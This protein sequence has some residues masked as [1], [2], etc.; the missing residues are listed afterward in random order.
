MRCCGAPG[1]CE[2]TVKAVAAG[3][4][5]VSVKER[6]QDGCGVFPPTANHLLHNRLDQRPSLLLELQLVADLASAAV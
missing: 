5:I 3:K 2:W 1:A 4:V 6:Q